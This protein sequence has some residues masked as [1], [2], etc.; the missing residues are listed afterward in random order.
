MA[1]KNQTTSK[2]EFD[3]QLKQALMSVFQS[4]QGVA[5]TPFQPYQFAQSTSASVPNPECFVWDTHATR[6]DTFHD[7]EATEG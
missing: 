5:Q 6:E 1:G 7:Q 2:S 4:G 3:P